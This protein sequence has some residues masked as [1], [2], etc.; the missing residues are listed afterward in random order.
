MRTKLIALILIVAA[1]IALPPVHRAQE[2]AA[3]ALVLWY[4]RPRR[5]GTRHCPWETGAWARWCSAA[6]PTSACSS[7]RI[8]CGPARSSIASIP[9][10][11]RRFRKSGGCCSR[12]S[13]SRLKRSRT[14]R[15]SP[16]AE[17]AAVPDVGDLAIHFSADGDASEYRRE[18]DLDD[19]IAR[20]RFR[21]GDTVYTREVFASAVDQVI[22][23]RVSADR[24]GRVSFSASLRR[25]S[26][27]ATRT[28]GNDVVME[29]RA[30]PTGERQKDERETGGPFP[31][32]ARPPEGGGNK[33]N[34]APS[35]RGG[36]GRRPQPPLGRGRKGS[37]GPP[38]GGGGGRGGGGARPGERTRRSSRGTPRGR[39]GGGG[40]CPKPTRRPPAPRPGGGE[41]G[42]GPTRERSKRSISSSA[43]TC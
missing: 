10:P 25:E 42:G 15:S 41:G 18:L 32:R 3:N 39:R 7:T 20:V 13:R 2:P 8:R 33:R 12:A 9:R 23:V 21:A 35:R 34:G 11:R 1:D 26:D 27:A 6:S 31:P 22:V 43:A 19:A 38:G 29:G 24:P 5:T 36:G 30:I 4:A 14:R 28:E 17:D 16:S 40:S 37:G